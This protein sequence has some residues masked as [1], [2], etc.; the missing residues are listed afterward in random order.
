MAELA[1]PY[2]LKSSMTRFVSLERDG[3]RVGE[4]MCV[5]EI[6]RERD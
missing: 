2:M 1:G 6:E 3:D 5:R 4:R